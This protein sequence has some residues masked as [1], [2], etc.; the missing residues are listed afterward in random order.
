[1]SKQ[2]VAVTKGLINYLG[3]GHDQ[4]KSEFGG[5]DDNGGVTSGGGYKWEQVMVLLIDYLDHGRDQG[6]VP[7][8]GR[9]HPSGKKKG[10]RDSFERKWGLEDDRYRPSLNHK[11]CRLGISADVA[12]RTPPAPYEK[13]KFLG[14]GGVWSQGRNLKELTEGHHQEWSS[15]LNLTQHGETYQIIAIV[16]LQR[17]IPSKRESSLALTTSPPFVHTA[18]RSYRLNGPVKCSDRGD[19]AVRRRRRREKSTEPYHLEEGEVVTRFP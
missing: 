2:V 3:H 14:S 7:N 15:R 19:A 8:G 6:V 1:M 17:G 10:G 4:G 13:S 16:G 18:R 11:R 12:F 9:F 5:R